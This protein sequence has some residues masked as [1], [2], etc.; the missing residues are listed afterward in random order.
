VQEADGTRTLQLAGWEPFDEFSGYFNGTIRRTPEGN[1]L[2]L[3][4]GTQLRLPDLPI[5]V[6]ADLPV[7]AEGGRVGDTLEWFILQV[8]P[9]DEGQLPPDLSQAQAV[10]D[11]VE[12]VYLAPGLSEVEPG[13]A[14]EP[15]YR[16]LI[17]AWSFSGHITVAGG[18]DL[19]VQAYVQAVPV[20]Q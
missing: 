7:Y 15:A 6:P 20:Q 9:A 4:D 3:E 18:Q 12:L 2:E 13:M 10:I 11:K 17:P 1:F 19:L 16:M 14:L 8:H 5:V